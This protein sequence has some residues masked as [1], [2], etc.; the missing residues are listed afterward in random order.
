MSQN[1]FISNA[2]NGGYSIKRALNEYAPFDYGFRVK[3]PRH[4]DKSRGLRHFS[5]KVCEKVKEKGQTNYN[6][7]ADELVAE[8]F[9]SL[10]DPPSSM[11]GFFL[12]K[13]FLN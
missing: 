2:N 1:R 9:D 8:Y 4:A 5:N 3:F 6:E 7:V 10:P 13:K 12:E 11:V